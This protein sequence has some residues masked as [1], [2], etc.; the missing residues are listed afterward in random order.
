MLSAMSC[1]RLAVFEF[2]SGARD[3]WRCAK[4]G[5]VRRQCRYSLAVFQ[6]Q[7]TRNL[8]ACI[9][10]PARAYPSV[11]AHQGSPNTVCMFQHTCIPASLKALKRGTQRMLSRNMRIYRSHIGPLHVPISTVCILLPLQCSLI[12]LTFQLPRHRFSV[13]F[14]GC[15]HPAISISALTS[16]PVQRC[17][18]LNHLTH[19]NGLSSLSS[20]N[21]QAISTLSYISR[22]PKGFLTYPRSGA[23]AL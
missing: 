23:T 1:V 22:I 10:I 21:E 15:L 6:I 5:T 14:H 7:I 19:N 9:C 8:D 18:I 20:S 3:S 13:F 4:C 12:S 2:A 17:L 11:L 16:W